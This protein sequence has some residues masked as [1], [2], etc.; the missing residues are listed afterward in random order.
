[1]KNNQSRFFYRKFKILRLFFISF[2][3]NAN[4]FTKN[5]FAKNFF[6]NLSILIAIYCYYKKAISHFKAFLFR[7]F[8]WF[9]YPNLIKIFFRES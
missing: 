1:M 4:F 9:I 2:F 5:F 8:V 3:F 7:L 6:Y